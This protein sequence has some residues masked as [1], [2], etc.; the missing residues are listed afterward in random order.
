MAPAKATIG[1]EA[2]LGLLLHILLSTLVN[3][4]KLILRRER[5]AEALLHDHLPPIVEPRSLQLLFFALFDGGD[6]GY[7]LR[8][9]RRRHIL[10]LILDVI[11]SHLGGEM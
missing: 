6:A 10:L 1:D 5:L 9:R 4:I 2:L 11:S 3:V 7:L 8:I